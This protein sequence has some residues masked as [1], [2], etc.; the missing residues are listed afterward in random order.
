MKKRIAKK[1]YKNWKLGKCHY[2][3]N[4]IIKALVKLL[5]GY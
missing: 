4:Q 3:K 5:K 1:I 2:S